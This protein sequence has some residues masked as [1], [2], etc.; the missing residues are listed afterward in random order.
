[1]LP[2]C[3]FVSPSPGASPSADRRFPVVETPRSGFVKSHGSS[4]QLQIGNNVGNMISNGEKD[5][6]ADFASRLAMIK[7]HP[8]LFFACFC[9]RRNVT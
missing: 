1:M 8:L 3:I 7:R 9:N 5:L 4:Q 2:A 6:L